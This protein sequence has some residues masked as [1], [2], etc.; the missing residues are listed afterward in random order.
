MT[1]HSSPLSTITSLN[2]YT[3]SGGGAEALSQQFHKGIFEATKRQLRSLA[4]ERKARAARAVS[5]AGDFDH[6]QWKRWRILRWRI[7]GRCWRRLIQIIHYSLQF[8]GWG[9]FFFFFWGGFNIYDSDEGGGGVIFRGS[10]LFQVWC[11]KRYLWFNCLEVYCAQFKLELK[12]AY[13]EETEGAAGE[14]LE[15]KRSAV[16]V[17]S[18]EDLH[19]LTSITINLID[20]RGDLASSFRWNFVH[21]PRE[22]RACRLGHSQWI[23][24]FFLVRHCD[25]NPFLFHLQRRDHPFCCLWLPEPRNILKDPW[26][27]EVDI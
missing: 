12:K 4:D 18:W 3:S 23:T 22:N 17:I 26:Y 11:W 1:P 6:D 8:Q 2:F 5:H 27:D 15:V 10:T 16:V 14:G 24:P 20:E 21:W 9:F 13:I 25:S 19:T 7:W